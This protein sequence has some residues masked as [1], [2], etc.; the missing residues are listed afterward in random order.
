MS[1]IED[2]DGIDVITGDEVEVEE[3]EEEEQ[4]QASEEEN[5]EPE[6]DQGKKEVS[7]GVLKK[8][9]KLTKRF[10]Q[11]R[12]E[13]EEL[14]RK[15]AEYENKAPQV[16]EEPKIEDFDYDDEAHK[17][18]LIKYNV[19]Q[20]MSE[21]D[22][23]NQELQGKSEQEKLN[24]DFNKKVAESGI[25]ESEYSESFN[26]LLESKIP[27]SNDVIEAIQSDDNG[28]HLTHYLGK[29]LEVADRIASM[30]PTQAAMELGKISTQISQSRVKKTTNAPDPVTTVGSGSGTISKD[31]SKS[32]MDDIMSDDSI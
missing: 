12:G 4:P 30:S 5:Q 27:F 15:L 24:E 16:S 26:N 25:P 17:A 8:I 21:R 2:L 14:K 11:E 19:Q 23:K 29:N 18:A 6:K 32:S 3:V 7:T 1:E 31:A 13:K 10:Y 22:Q 20:A 28:A 9:N